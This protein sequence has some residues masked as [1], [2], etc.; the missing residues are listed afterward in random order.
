VNAHPLD[1]ACWWALGTRHRHLSEQRGRARRYRPGI[2][3]F[4]AGET[5]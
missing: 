2:T 1:N 3:V 5:S 4:G